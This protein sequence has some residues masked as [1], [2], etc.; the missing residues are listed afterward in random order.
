MATDYD[1]PRTAD[2]DQQGEPALQALAGSQPGD[3]PTRRR[4]RPH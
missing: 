2:D 3:P 4:R 1:A